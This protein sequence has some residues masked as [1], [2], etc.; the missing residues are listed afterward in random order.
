MSLF[1]H[2]TRASVAPPRDRCCTS[3][4]RMMMMIGLC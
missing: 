4:T 1:S 3:C 2:W